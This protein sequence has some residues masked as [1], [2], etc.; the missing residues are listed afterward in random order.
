MLT[1]FNPATGSTNEAPGSTLSTPQIRTNKVSWVLT[2]DCKCR[3]ERTCTSTGAYTQVQMQRVRTSL[4]AGA[5]KQ[6][7][8][9]GD[10]HG[11]RM[12]SEVGHG[13][14]GMGTDERG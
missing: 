6:A 7:G 14:A 4:S 5:Y 11:R 9:G 1:I 2:N 3:H 10:E 12:S 13:Q 8:T